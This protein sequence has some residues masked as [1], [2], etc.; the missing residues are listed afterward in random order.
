[1]PGQSLDSVVA[2]SY[3]FDPLAVHCY[4]WHG[5]QNREQNYSGVA[6]E[7]HEAFVAGS[8]IVTT[9]RSHLF[10]RSVDCCYC[11]GGLLRRLLPFGCYSSL[12]K[13]H[14]CFH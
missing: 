13:R 1:M 3:S 14:P 9:T 11:F 12:S 2:T 5:N 6:T 8:G 7:V 10:A 4:C